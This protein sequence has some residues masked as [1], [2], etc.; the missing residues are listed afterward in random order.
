MHL[1]IFAFTYITIDTALIQKTEKMQDYFFVNSFRETKVPIHWLLFKIF[2]LNGGN[3]V[4][5]CIRIE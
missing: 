4:L 3:N 2:V 5:I 1:T